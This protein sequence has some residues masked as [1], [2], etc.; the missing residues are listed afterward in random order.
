MTRLP[1]EPLPDRHSFPPV[2]QAD[3]NGL[4]AIGGD[5]S[6]ERL[7]TAY[8]QGIFP[9]YGEPPILWFSPDPR[10]VLPL[11]RLHVARRLRRTLRQGRFAFTLDGA[12]GQVIRACANARRREGGGTWIT[13][14]MIEAYTRLHELGIAHSI[15]A[16]RDG[17]LLGGVYGV[18][19][20]AAFFAESMFHRERDASKAALCA[21]VWQLEAWRF[22]LFDCQVSSPHLIRLGAEE[23]PRPRFVAALHQ[24]LAKPTRRGRWQLDAS[25]LAQRLCP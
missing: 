22:E 4:L 2:D 25:E 1:D 16:W 14:E 10:A 18:S 11:S 8:S 24:A 21:L 7:L 13:P 15:E 12:F 3:P 23:W 6:P 5:L 9:W 20:G 19:L 17:A